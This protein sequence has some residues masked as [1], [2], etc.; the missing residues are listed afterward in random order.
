MNYLPLEIPKELSDF[1][2]SVFY[3]GD[4][5]PEHKIERLI[6]DG[7]ISLVIELDGNERYIYDNTNFEVIQRCTNFW[8]SGMH[9]HYISI[10]AIPY[11]ELVGI[12]FKAGGLFPFINSDVYK[13]FNSVSDA[14]EYF[15]DSITSLRKDLINLATP[16]DKL[17]LISDWLKKQCRF[18]DSVNAVIQNSCQQILAAPTISTLEEIRND[19]P[20]SEK[21]FIHNFKTQ[22]GITPKVF[23]RIIRFNQI[24][25]RLKE[26]ETI[27]WAEISEEC[28]Y[29]DQPHFIRDFKQF[30]GFNPSEFLDSSSGRSNFIP[31]K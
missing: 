2:D 30:S 21:Q 20:Y 19:I 23:Q 17:E 4:Y 15:Q 26:Q 24:L 18:T 3:L 29:F 7:M 16:V 6:P 10:S 28:G 8:L 14:S 11:T 27:E 9:N 13:L 5:T 12:R 1:V 25:P 31:L 22:I